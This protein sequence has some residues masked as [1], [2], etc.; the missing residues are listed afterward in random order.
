MI[1]LP[2]AVQV[3]VMRTV[4]GVTRN[5]RST[6]RCTLCDRIPEDDDKILRIRDFAHPDPGVHE[7]VLHQNCVLA[8]FAL[9]DDTDLSLLYAH[10]GN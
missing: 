7:T 3:A 5:I 10:I 9:A 4:D 8:L 2:P 1:E 6:V